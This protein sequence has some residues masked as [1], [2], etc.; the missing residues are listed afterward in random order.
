MERFN[1]KLLIRHRHWI[2]LEFGKRRLGVCARCSGTILGFFSLIT[3]TNVTELSAFSNLGLQQQ[4][5]VC[6]LL[7]MP[8]GLDW[9]SQAY[10]LRESTNF[11]RGA[12]GF[13]EGFSVGLFS[14]AA[15]PMM[16]KFLTVLSI[17]GAISILGILGKRFAST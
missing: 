11:L 9:L 12:T 8:S 4:M 2:T 14:L 7:I 15:A 10:G 3:L 13:L 5:L 1:W 16:F 17:G 6:V